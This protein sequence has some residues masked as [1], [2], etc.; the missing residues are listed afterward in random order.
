MHPWHYNGSLAPDCDQRAPP[1]PPPCCRLI[2]EY[3]DAKGGE[4]IGGAGADRAEVG[5]WMDK[6]DAWDGN[7]FVTGT[8][9]GP[10][11]GVLGSIESF[12]LK[13]AQARCAAGWSPCWAAVRGGS[14]SPG[15]RCWGGTALLGDSIWWAVLC[16]QCLSSGG[17]TWWQ[18]LVA[19]VG[20]SSWS[21]RGQ[22]QALGVLWKGC[23]RAS[24]GAQE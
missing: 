17:S 12:R 22:H 6:L 9:K 19:A 7:L 13:Y 15:S 11:K 10:V 5:K 4:T 14:T 20:G 18:P 3:V 23:K 1:G 21:Q 2:V 24:G 16:G 8:V